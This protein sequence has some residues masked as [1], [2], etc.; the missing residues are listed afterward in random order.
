MKRDID[1]EEDS[2]KE[3]NKETENAL[4]ELYPDK[5]L[6]ISDILKNNNSSQL[7]KPPSL[8]KS[9]NT[10]SVEKNSKSVMSS[11][12][13]KIQNKNSHRVGTSFN[14]PYHNRNNSINVV[15]SNSSGVE[16]INILPNIRPKSPSDSKHPR[17]KYADPLGLRRLGVYK[18]NKFSLSHKSRD[19]GV[20]LPTVFTLFLHCLE[21]FRPHSSTYYCIWENKKI[22]K[23]N[24][25]W[26]SYIY[27]ILIMN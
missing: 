8:S 27:S 19:Y 7:L 1:F 20:S 17:S 3:D 26:I 15:S 11:Y 13:I 5:D 14:H 4:K 23:V 12:G 24:T 10:I 25:I 9:M 2:D 21:F 22:W 6:K 18:S 16:L